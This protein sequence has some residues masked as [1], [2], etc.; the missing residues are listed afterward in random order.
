NKI[1][2]LQEQ[3]TQLIELQKDQKRI[4]SLENKLEIERK[5]SKDVDSW[6]RKILDNMI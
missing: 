2:H 4:K 3:I 6:Y 5:H 1:D